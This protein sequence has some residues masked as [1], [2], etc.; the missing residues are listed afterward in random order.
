MSWIRFRTPLLLL[1]GAACGPRET[2]SAEPLPERLNRLVAAGDTVALA[3]LAQEQCRAHDGVERQNCYED[4]FVALS[5]SGRVALALGALATLG[6]LEEKVRADGHVYTH[7]IGIKAW[8]PG[9]DVAA[10]F[11]SCN[12]L[13]Q[14][15]CY[16]GVIQAYFT[17]DG[18]VDSTKVANLCDVIE[19]KNANR[20]L[21]FQCVHGIGH[22][23]EMIWNWD[24]LRALKGCDWLVTGWD[25]QS[26]YG[27]A[28]MENAVASMP[29]GHHAPARVLAGQAAPAAADEPAEHSEHSDHQ[30]Q[31]DP[32]AI[33]FKMRD[34][35]D[36]LY[37]C[38]IVEARY[39][40]SC[41][42]LQGG[43]ILQARG[44]DFEKGA[45]ECDRAPEGVR[46]FCYLSMG[47]MASGMTVQNAR[48]SIRHCSNGDPGYRPWCFVGAV[49][50]FI[51]VTA[52]PDDGIAF[53]RE[54][55]SGKDQR[56]C[57]VAVGEQIAVLHA[58]P[59]GREKACARTPEGG[60]REE[61]RYGAGLLPTPPAGL[62]ILPG[63]KSD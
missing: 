60:P 19:G 61:C 34:S 40:T 48:Q 39:W 8:K 29:G 43:M 11:A 6:E 50:N 1:L 57:Y 16:H 26:C 9:R 44:M 62:P 35:A 23:L 63:S 25:R 45:E 49:K 55:P 37:P 32:G 54:V 38:T 47:T 7:V 30:G 2:Q 56:Q 3:R 15:G 5:D 33:T 27:G 14:S 22:G 10:I 42:M 31:L 41:Y 20:W 18:G 52:D 28:F 21:R 17:S 36:A 51:D 12:G 24:L 53:C 58:E 4:Y 59:E 46:Q 13:F